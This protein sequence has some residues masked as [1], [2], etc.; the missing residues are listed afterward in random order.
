MRNLHHGVVPVAVHKVV[1]S[2]C[3]GLVQ[4]IVAVCRTFYCALD[5]TCIHHHALVRRHLEFADSSLD[6]GHLIKVCEFPLAVLCLDL[7]SPYL[8]LHQEIYT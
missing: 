7:T 4:V 2:V 5:I 3:S 8:S 6:V 1:C